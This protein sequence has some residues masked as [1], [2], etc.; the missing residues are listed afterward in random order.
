MRCTTGL[1]HPCLQCL[2]CRINARRIWTGRLML[3]AQCHEHSFFSTF[4]YK[5][6]PSDGSVHK[7]HISAAFHRLRKAAAGCGRRVRFFAVGEY[8]DRFFR[9]HY[10]AAVFGLSRGDAQ[11]ISEAWS[12]LRDP[13]FGSEPGFCTHGDLTPASAGYIAGYVTK[14]LTAKASTVALAKL[15][16]RLPE[17]AVMSRRP[18]IGLLFIQALVEGLNT[19]EGALFIART[20]DVPVSVSVGGRLLPL[21]RTV[22]DHLR[23]QF[24][25]ET[26]QPKSAKEKASE[27]FNLDLKKYLPS[28]PVDASPVERAVFMEANREAVAEAHAKHFK[29][30]KAR[31]I[32]VAIRHSISTSKR[33]L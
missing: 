18:G 26:G 6:E 27:A 20:G 4:T 7:E 23:L 13:L 3:E 12:G 15:G 14:K 28:M 32:Q 10:H 2:A 11:L 30:L 24:F 16:G 33:T 19:S 29:T 31:S 22:R 1:P 17:F 5:K 9:P 25:G 8:G 21:G